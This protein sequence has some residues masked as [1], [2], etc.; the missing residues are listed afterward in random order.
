[1]PTRPCQNLINYLIKGVNMQ[2]PTHVTFGVFIQIILA[3][4]YPKTDP[5]FFILV[6]TFSLGSHFLL[7]S[8][9][10]MTYHPPD[11]QLT[12]FWL[13]WHILVYTSGTVF[14]ISALIINPWFIV[15]ILGA[16]LPDLWDW[17]ILRWLLKSTNKKLYVHKFANKI[18]SFFKSY[19]PDLTYN[20]KG[21]V[22]EFI[23]IILVSI[24]IMNFIM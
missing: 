2:L 6:F 4:L 10:I 18:R 14:I 16:N 22:P 9:A 24:S 3:I 11:R 23:L 8:L 13:Y 7:D 1:M 17:I 21:I 15:G 20:K 12:N 19:V 5:L